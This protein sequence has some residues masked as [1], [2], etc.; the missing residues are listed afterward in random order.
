MDITSPKSKT[1]LGFFIFLIAALAIAFAIKSVLPHIWHG[2][3]SIFPDD[4]TGIVTSTG[5][6]GNWTM[7]VNTCD[8][9]QLKQ[10]FGIAFFDKAQPT[11]GGRIVLPESGENHLSV[12]IPNTSLGSKFNQSDCPLW[13]VHLEQTNNSYNYVRVMTGHAHFDCQ[14]SQPVP[15]HI[16]GNLQFRSCH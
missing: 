3:A 1:A 12:N 2:A 16:S 8:S 7:H 4:A 9:G 10:Y 14:Y 6:S 15:A 11:L 13:D 5:E